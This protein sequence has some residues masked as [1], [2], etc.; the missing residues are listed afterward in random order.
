MLQS[1][2]Y[3][4][5]IYYIIKNL[6]KITKNTKI[7]YKFIFFKLFNWKFMCEF[8]FFCSI[9]IFWM[10]IYFI[11]KKKKNE[12][13]CFIDTR[14]MT[15]CFIFKFKYPRLVVTLIK[16]TLSLLKVG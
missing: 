3:S 6:C 7:K 2:I 8:D 1:H 16:I 15:F 4:Y 9:S 10:Q 11:K 13:R 12:H 5:F 14:K